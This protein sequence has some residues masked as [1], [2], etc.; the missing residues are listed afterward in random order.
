M[1]RSNEGGPSGGAKYTITDAGMT[2]PPMYWHQD[3]E[4]TSYQWV[5]RALSSPTHDGKNRNNAFSSLSLD[6][7]SD[8]PKTPDLQLEASF[9]PMHRANSLP[10]LMDQ[11]PAQE[12][13]PERYS[14]LLRRESR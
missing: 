14:P 11:S 1:E 3:I 13:S 5:Q 6:A 8:K 10:E 4:Y 7:E 9:L 2:I 12:G